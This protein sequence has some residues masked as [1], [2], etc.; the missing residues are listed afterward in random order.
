MRPRFFFLLP[1]FAALAWAAGGGSCQDRP[2][3]LTTPQGLVGGTALTLKSGQL[4]FRSACLVG[5]G[6]RFEAREIVF[7]RASKR[8]DASEAKGEV[9]GWRFS[10]ARLVAQ[11]QVVEFADATFSR[12][13]LEVHAEAAERRGDAVILT[14]IR[15]R[16]PRY[17][18]RADGG[19]L[20]AGRF[21]AE[22]I[23]ATPC[24]CGEALVLH[25]DRAVFDAKSGRLLVEE[26]QVTFY[27][28][29]LARPDPLVLDTSAPIELR[30]PLRLTYA[31][32][33]W[34]VGVVD[35]P[36]FVPGES[37]G[38]WKTRI[39]A[40]GEGLGGPSPRYTLSLVDGQN[41]FGMRFA[42][43]DF[44]LSLQVPDLTVEKRLKRDGGGAYLRYHPG[45]GLG[46]LWLGPSLTFLDTGDPGLTFGLSAKAAF[47]GAWQ[48][49]RYTLRPWVETT[50]YPDAAPYVVAG[51]SL[52][53][54]MGDVR[55]VYSRSEAWG[56]PR[57][58]L[59]KRTP[60]ES[61]LLAYGPASLKWSRNLQTGTG[62]LDLRLNTP[63][64]L[65]LSTGFSGS[66]ADRLEATLGYRAPDPEAGGFALSP[67]LGYDLTS[68]GVSRAGFDLAYSD[69]CFVYTLGVSSVLLPWPGEAQGTRVVMGMRLK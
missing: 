10:A 46:A 57:Y 36:L 64:W 12:G 6:V 43:K 44:G 32:D 22:G 35:L 26:S 20:E 9:G 5:E 59:E 1:I 49:V 61:A 68:R 28:L 2:Y 29:T 34:T 23:W 19:R 65:R 18:F 25:G 54:W 30:F 62:R 42:E 14:R 11:D 37:F 17:R 47:S 60:S 13:R 16:T 21:V 15:A 50:L 31:D 38:A 56:T 4:R 27:G 52:Q 58:F 40:L 7:D 3:T 48:G 8:L 53:L 33:G 55:A 45:F 41:R 66:T 51:G 69:G 63:L 39:S 24:R 67:Y